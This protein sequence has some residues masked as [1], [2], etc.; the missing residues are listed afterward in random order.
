MF[1]IQQICFCNPMSTYTLVCL[2]MFCSFFI[3]IIRIQCSMN[4]EWIESG[5]LQK[6]EMN[7]RIMKKWQWQKMSCLFLISLHMS[8]LLYSF[9]FLFVLACH[10]SWRNVGRSWY[11]FGNTDIL[12]PY[13]T[14]LV[15]IPG[16]Q[17]IADCKYM[18]TWLY[19]HDKL[20]VVYLITGTYWK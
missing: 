14:T 6:E 3:S 4:G 8:S 12:Q 16:L 9:S 5:K 1:G 2:Y 11:W 17:P 20:H 15:W 18:I 10:I 19:S 13:M 7:L